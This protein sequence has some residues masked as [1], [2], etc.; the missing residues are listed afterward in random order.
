MLSQIDRLAG[1][2][3]RS[4]FQVRC[5]MKQ[6]DKHIVVL[7]AGYAGLMAA[8]RLAK[9][10]DARRVNITL[11]NA[12]ETFNERVRNHQLATGQPVGKHS[13]TSLLR[14]TRIQLRLGT[15]MALHPA[16][17]LVTIETESGQ[18]RIG[19]DYLVYA[20]GSFVAVDD[21]PGA[22]RYA[23][24]LDQQS[25]EALAQRLSQLAEQKGRLLIVGGGNTGVETAA[26]IA[27]TYR[28]LSITLVTRHSFAHNLSAAARR[29]VHKVYDRLGITFA[30]NTHVVELRADH[31]IT[32]NG[33]SIPFDA[34]AWVGGF[35]V[36]DLAR[37][38]G[39]Q[40]N[41]RNQ[42]LIDRAMRSIS[43]PEIYAV[44]DAAFPLAEPGA[45]MRMSLY[46]AIMMGGHGAD[47]LAAHLNGKRPT[48]FGLSYVALGISLGRK[49]GVFQF[50]N[51]NKD[52]PLNLII[53]GRLGNLSREFFVKFALWVIKIQRA[54][55]WVF[56]WPGRRKMRKVAVDEPA[57][58]QA[59]RMVSGSATHIKGS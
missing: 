52:T 29:H 37:R 6:S 30:E 1:L 5:I 59:P 25:A 8:M 26:E 44:G 45:P 48:A 36:S 32:S 47:S 54:L 13:L 22:K 42:I 11:I 9:K 24:T 18:Q 15:V 3:Y 55:P 46:T 2:I 41:D 4:Q 17:R 7:G 57:K 53:T 31:A 16:K 49:D 10:S 23:Y 50:L 27:E 28:G 38:A 39:L 51:W 35:A 14:G 40:V 43:H 20:L 33:V 21:T 19:Y 34:C 12:G 58:S 56:E